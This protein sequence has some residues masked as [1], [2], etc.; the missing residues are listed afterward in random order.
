M[1]LQLGISYAAKMN[2]EQI[3]LLRLDKRKIRVAVFLVEL[4]LIEM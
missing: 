4:L 3:E 2:L 1:N